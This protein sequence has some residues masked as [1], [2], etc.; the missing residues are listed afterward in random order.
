MNTKRFY[1]DFKKSIVYLPENGRTFNTLSRGYSVSVFFAL[2]NV[3][4]DM[5]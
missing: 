1:E 5:D 3:V 2:L 4:K